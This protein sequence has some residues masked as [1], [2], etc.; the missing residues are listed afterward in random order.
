[1]S[2]P[3]IKTDRL[4]FIELTEEHIND[5]FEQYSD[6][7]A[8]KYWDGFPHKDTEETHKLVKRLRER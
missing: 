2:F 1:M 3:L 7:E 8:M 4:Q 6:E 5:L